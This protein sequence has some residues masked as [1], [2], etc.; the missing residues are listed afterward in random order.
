MLLYNKLYLFNIID[1]ERL[2]QNPY[3]GQVSIEY[4][5]QELYQME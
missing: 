1:S 2:T 4:A 5:E 3:E